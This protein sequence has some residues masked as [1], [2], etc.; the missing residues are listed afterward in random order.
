[1]AKKICL[2]G[3]LSALCIVFGFIEHLIS[4]D[5]IAPGIKIGLANSVA[6]LLIVWG[7]KQGAIAVNLVRIL[8]SALLFSNPSVLYYSL[9]GGVI[10]FIVMVIFSKFN[11]V[12]IIGLSIAGAV[13]HNITQLVCAQLLL[14]NGIW[15]YTPILLVSALLGGFITGT[16]ASI[17]FKKIK[18]T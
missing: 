14:G 5:F 13:A 8:L 10:S 3:V 17:V 9:S 4:F 1:M 2:Y 6:L 15:Y 11:S 12:S 18:N 16:A 7:D